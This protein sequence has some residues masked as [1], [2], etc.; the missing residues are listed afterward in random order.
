[1]LGILPNPVIGGQSTVGQVTLDRPAPVGDLIV[2]L[3]SGDPATAVVPAVVIIPAG[4]TTALF[5]IVTFPVAAL[6][7]V[8]LTAI[9][10]GGSRPA[11]LQVLPVDT[12]FPGGNLLVN[13]G[14]E[15]PP[16][17][18]EAPV[19][20]LPGWRITRGSINLVPAG[21]W[22]PAPDGG[23]QSLDLVGDN[24]QPLPGAIEQTIP[25][26]PGRLYLFSG[27]IAHN[28]G[29]PVAPE[30]RANVMLDGQFFVQ[31][32]HRDA[33]ATPAAMR[34]THFA[35][36]FGATGA[37][38][39]LALADVTG[40]WDRGGMALDG[41]SVA[42]LME[43]LLVNGS[44]EEP[45]LSAIASGGRALGPGDLPGWQIVQGPAD[46]IDQRRWQPAPSQ[47][48][49]TLHLASS[50]GAAAIEQTIPTDPGRL[51]VLSGWLSRSPEIDAARLTLYLNG[52]LLIALLH[53]SALYGAQT[54]ADMRWQ[55]FLTTF[56][57]TGPTTAL[58]FAD[59][60]GRGSAGAAAQD[61][62]TVV[63]AD[64]ASP[65]GAPAAPTGLQTRLVM[66]NQVDL[67]W[68][69]NR[70]NETGFEIQRR[71]PTGDFTRI[72][73]VAANTTRFIDFAVS[74]NTRYTYRVRAQ[75]DTGPS[76]WSNE[77]AVT[78]LPVR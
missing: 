67:A 52:K 25:T 4:A 19:P 53:S 59:T 24:S 63:P 73:L 2:T 70:A 66:P 41:L 51:Y 9:G 37:A 34:W 42:P 44:F 50:L 60:S 74:P 23:S 29:N 71:G 54:R 33:L 56:R 58:R 12:R 49:Q 6:T 48:G 68:T 47:G 45:D 28:P 20:Q 78:T 36:R 75:N 5:S 3:A 57:A 30:G 39:T 69:D 8:N 43:S 14:F 31:L 35:Y 16:A 61:G 72:A 13:G 15:A 55:P 10:P 62:L 32:F 26:F 1:V 64:E 7:V 22:Q 11:V 21:A 38:T 18:S 27:W 40:T 77:L 65:G 46:L 76:A 17:Q